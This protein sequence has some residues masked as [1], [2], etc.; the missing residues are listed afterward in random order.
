[1]FVP[2]MISEE[3][4][5]GKV[6]CYQSCPGED[7]AVVVEISENENQDAEDNE[8]LESQRIEQAK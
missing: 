3:E 1:M 4:S 6:Q 8:R 5:N 2:K 7:A